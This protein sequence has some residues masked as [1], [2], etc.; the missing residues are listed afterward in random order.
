LAQFQ[1]LKQ[2]VASRQALVAEVESGEV[3]WSGILRDVSMVIPDNMYLTSLAGSVNSS[4][5]AAGAAPA[6]VSGV[7]LIG[8]IQFQGIAGDYPT[9]AKWLTRVEEVTG[10]VNP[11][12]NSATKDSAASDGRVNFNGSLDLSLDATIHGV[13]Q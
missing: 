13:P 4:S 9:V 1:D 11:W 2:T 6:V 3:Q 5:A 8:N 7:G 10:W 12:A